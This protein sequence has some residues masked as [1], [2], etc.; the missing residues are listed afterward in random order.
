MVPLMTIFTPGMKI[1]YV[2]INSASKR[3]EVEPFFADEEHPKPDFNYYAGRVAKTLARLTDVW[4]Y[5]EVALLT[6]KRQPKQS[7]LF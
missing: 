5:D 2:V 1:S 7:T 4:D 3:Q 6:G